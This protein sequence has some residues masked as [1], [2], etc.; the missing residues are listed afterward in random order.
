MMKSLL[1]GV[2]AIAMV[3]SAAAQTMDGTGNEDDTNLGSEWECS[4]TKTAD[5][6]RDPSYKVTVNV[7]YDA[8]KITRVYHTLQSGK[9]AN[10]SDQ[11]VLEFNGHAKAGAHMWAGHYKKNSALKM[12]GTL[13]VIKG[14]VYY[15]EWRP[16]G[17]G[18][19]PIMESVCH[20][21]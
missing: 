2:A 5:R 11:Y 4:V 20:R 7:D 17:N 19:V 13:G 14:K 1:A 12:T 8:D 3:V 10:R 6:D 18:M 21:A 16:R 9:I 15:M